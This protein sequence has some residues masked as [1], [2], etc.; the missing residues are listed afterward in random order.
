M[1]TEF[2]IPDIQRMAAALRDSRDIAI[3]CHLS[4]D[5]DALGSSLGLKHV[6]SRV[7]PAARVRVIT[8]DEPTAT[9]SFLPGFG[10]TLPYT[11]YRERVNTFM[12][13]ADLVV[14]LDYND[15]H[16]IDLLQEAFNRSHGLILHIDHHL[17]PEPFGHIVF[18]FP[19][20]SAT[21]MLLYQL[22]VACGMENDID[23][24]AATCLLTGVMTD[25]GDLSYNIGDP[26]IYD[27]VSGLVRHGAD[28]AMLTRIL[29]NTFTESNLRIQGFAL[30]ER[31]EVFHD[32]HAAL[33]VLSR[34]DLN[35]F[36]YKKGDTEGLVN[37]PLAIPGIIYSAYLREETDYIKVSMRSLADFPV[38]E[39]CS[40][41]F[42]GGGHRNA[43]GGEFYGS[44]EECA[45]KF[46]SLL[47]E[48]KLKYIHSSQEVQTELTRENALRKK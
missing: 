41:Y 15:L 39:L 22:L 28:K 33:V 35:K 30:A 6:L 1:T 45:A 48:N 43:A 40:R 36:N 11:R 12:E 46:R 3:T 10:E 24:D 38:N 9:L 5:G 20:K 8:P 44:M 18:S 37:K 7:N 14:A 26:D 34:D 2:A 16:R 21:C 25:T 4:P 32:A 19:E 47:A 42:G 31:L 13:K 17:Y 29:F 27:V 23:T